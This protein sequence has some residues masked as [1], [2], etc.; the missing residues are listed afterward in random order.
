MTLV[1]EAGQR[2]AVG[3]TAV[4]VG[5]A[6][7]PTNR[8]VSVVT[9]HIAKNFWP[10]GNRTWA[11]RNHLNLG[12][13]SSLA[14]TGV[15]PA[16]RTADGRGGC[17]AK[18]IAFSAVPLVNDFG[19]SA[20]SLTRIRVIF[21]ILAANGI[22][23]FWARTQGRRGRGRSNLLAVSFFGEF[24][25]R[26]ADQL[27]QVVVT[28]SVSPANIFSAVWTLGMANSVLLEVFAVPFFRVARGNIETLGQTPILEGPSF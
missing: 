6:V 23:N 15:V 22:Q 26:L 17:R 12:T 1:S 19:F 9:G 7:K 4:L 14:G 24:G 28:L 2:A 3:L 20:L 25:R 11:V 18:T 27:A 8:I 13:F 10:A 21:A 5:P 16:V